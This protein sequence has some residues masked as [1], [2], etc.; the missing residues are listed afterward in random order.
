MPHLYIVR[1]YLI[2]NEKNKH[3]FCKELT[4]S[5]AIRV[6]E[7]MFVFGVANAL[8]LARIQKQLTPDKLIPF[9]RKRW[10]NAK[11]PYNSPPQAENLGSQ[12]KIM[13]LPH[14]HLKS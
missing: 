10:E 1:E 8:G 9:L 7:L 11:F 4:D 13:R 3:N 5:V 14:I 6:E 12:F 2:V